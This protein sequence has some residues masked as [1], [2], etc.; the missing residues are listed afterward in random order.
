[1]KT[2]ALGYLFVPS[3]CCVPTLSL[4]LFEAFKLPCISLFSGIA[5]LEL[6]LSQPGS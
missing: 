4:T 6:G 1:M 3:R 5:G 2:K